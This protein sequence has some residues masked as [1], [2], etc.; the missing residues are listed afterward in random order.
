MSNIKVLRIY[1][2]SFL[3][4]GTEQ[5]EVADYNLKSSADGST[6]LS[7]IIKGCTSIF[8]SSASLGDTQGYTNPISPLQRI[9]G[10]VEEYFHRQSQ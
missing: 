1:N 6:E 4:I 10:Y 5:V 9:K 2:R 8:E 7:V 3:Q